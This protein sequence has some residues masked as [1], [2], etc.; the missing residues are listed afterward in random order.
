MEGT[1]RVKRWL[2]PTLLFLLTN[3]GVALAG[4]FGEGANSEITVVNPARVDGTLWVDS[5][6]AYLVAIREWQCWYP[7][8]WYDDVVIVDADGSFVA[9]N[10]DSIYY[11]YVVNRLGANPDL[12]ADIPL[13]SDRSCL[14]DAFIARGDC[15]TDER[16]A[17]LSSHATRD[18]FLGEVTLAGDF[19]FEDRSGLYCLVVI[20]RDPWHDL[21][22]DQSYVPEPVR[23]TYPE[24]RTLV[25]LD[26]RVWYDVAPGV[27][28]VRDG[29]SLAIE[30]AGIDYNLT[31]EIWLAEIRVDTDGD[32]T[33]DFAK[34]CPA[35]D[36]EQLDLCAGSVDTPIFTFQYE[37]RAFHPFTIETRWG[38]LAVDPD[39][40]ALDIDP[41]LLM[42]QYTFDWETVEVRS[43]LDG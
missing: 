38:G 16:I 6:G 19:D 26:N 30:T 27:D 34:Q 24:L 41:N 28:R 2:L 17:V 7:Q 31:L 42:S 11:D 39:G 4:G 29:F 35:T 8:D 37:N 14:Q 36:T 15:S 3:P 12:F 10:P 20:E 23:A 40:I 32:G 43:S 22:R 21:I 33:W 13:Y 25:G 5:H 1:L 18:A 9:H